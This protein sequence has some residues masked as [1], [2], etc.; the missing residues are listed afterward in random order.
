MSIQPANP[1]P[2]AD[3]LGFV[4]A[5][6]EPLRE[7]K[8]DSGFSDIFESARQDQGHG[9]EVSLNQS[10]SANSR[11]GDDAEVGE[12][13]AQASDVAEDL[14]GGQPVSA[15]QQA[16]DEPDSGVRQNSPSDAQVLPV[17][18]PDQAVIGG[19]VDL[20]SETLIES[21]VALENIVAA[22]GEGEMK[23]GKNSVAHGEAALAAA[24]AAQISRSGSV[25]TDVVRASGEG[26][27][28]GSRQNL[29]TGMS[30]R[31]FNAQQA[32]NP[33]DQNSLAAATGSI[34]TGNERLAQG[35]R[36]ALSKLRLP[37][38][39]QN[40]SA[41]RSAALSMEQFVASGT[42]GRQHLSEQVLAALA[43]AKTLN[44]NEG[45]RADG[46]LFRVTE[47][48]IN[49]SPS[50]ETGRTVTGGDFKSA[51]VNSMSTAAHQADVVRQMGQQA[52][53]MLAGKMQF[54][55]L[56]LSPASLGSVEILVKQDNEQ[57]SLLFFSKN[58]AVREA[59]ENNLLRL[60]KSFEDEGLM[61][62]QASVSDQSLAE[63]QE[64]SEKDDMGF[65]AGSEQAVSAWP[66]SG[67]VQVEQDGLLNLWA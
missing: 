50:S 55:E 34:S 46:S 21:E 2:A 3:Q 57:T 25:R 4:S 5:N 12:A 23:A 67:T 47:A 53:M 20:R 62:G 10:V 1:N 18:L 65:Y 13:I 49:F 54:A 37:P 30:D 24:R 40:A 51:F 43:D 32:V 58:P 33:L 36:E 16:V 66:E 52:R 8:Q 42:A 11:Q 9:K 28:I 7:A 29:L 38:V 31:F 56:K 6:T 63:H 35:L 60:Q 39:A 19:S 26:D 17:G 27:F 14:E 22:N 64:Q 41:E 15:A 61:L 45:A 44:L 59:I 48:A